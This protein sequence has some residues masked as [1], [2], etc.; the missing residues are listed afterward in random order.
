MKL[1]LSGICIGHCTINMGEHAKQES[2]IEPQTF[3]ST[4]STRSTPL[5]KNESSEQ[6]KQRL[7]SLLRQHGGST[8]EKSV[9]D[10][11][12][13][14]C[15]LNPHHGHTAEWLHLFVGEFLALTCSNFPGRL[16][17]DDPN[18]IQ[19]TLG[20]LSFNTFQP[21]NLICTLRG[22]RNIVF[23]RT[24]GTY[25]HDLICDITVHLPDGDVDAE[26]WNKS[27]CSKVAISNRMNVYFTGS[28]MS[29]SP[30]V[31]E[32][33][34]M[35]A[36]WKNT[37]NQLAFEEAE[38]ERSFVQRIGHSFLRRFLGITLKHDTPFSVG[39]QFQKPF[40]GHLD[41]L[42]VDEEIRITKGNRGTIV[43]VE[44]LE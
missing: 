23:P 44:R 31:Q 2:E 39:L 27:Y 37:F 22:V 8:S 18:L 20:R 40:E 3:T 26:I 32:D 38:T 7:R 17:T 9:S 34:E 16:K 24:D 14:L 5:N 19:Y 25:T 41:V 4:S 43:I 29:P 21:Q 36:I 42:Y 10:T 1:R 35:M 33:E 11:I 28:T 15:G 6:L 12:S 13:Q 30:G